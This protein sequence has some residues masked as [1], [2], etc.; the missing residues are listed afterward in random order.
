MPKV[1]LRCNIADQITKIVS[2][3]APTSTQCLKNLQDYYLLFTQT[4][5]KVVNYIF[6]HTVM[7]K[8]YPFPGGWGEVRNCYLIL[9][10]VVFISPI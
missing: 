9:Y 8:L 7:V 10:M 6:G 1:C 3:D 4:Q 2:T 5:S